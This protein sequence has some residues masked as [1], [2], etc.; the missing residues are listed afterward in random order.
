MNFI[1]KHNDAKSKSNFAKYKPYHMAHMTSIDLDW[2]DVTSWKVMICNTN[3]DKYWYWD[4]EQAGYISN[5][6]EN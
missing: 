5:M 1:G 6:D 2:P 4:T 3:S